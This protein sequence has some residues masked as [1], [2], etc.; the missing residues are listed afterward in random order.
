MKVGNNSAWAASAPAPTPS[1]DPDSPMEVLLPGTHADQAALTA[2]LA[3]QY[4][5]WTVQKYGH[6]HPKAELTRAIAIAQQHYANA[7][8][9]MGVTQTPVNV[10]WLDDHV[11]SKISQ[12][13]THISHLSPAL[14]GAIRIS[15]PQWFSNGPNIYSRS[16]AWIN[17]SPRFISIA[18]CLWNAGLTGISIGPNLIRITPRLI[19]VNARG[20]NLSPILID[21]KSRGIDVAPAAFNFNGQTTHVAVVPRVIRWSPS[22]RF[23][24]VDEWG[25]NPMYV[26]LA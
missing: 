12:F 7:L 19:N 26:P 10:Q 18:P 5:Q 14:A 1:A 11:R 16:R 21:L 13:T 3:H 2:H 15:A 23:I 6:A 8:A 17:I 25:P 4:H 20:V 9:V 24:N 22:I